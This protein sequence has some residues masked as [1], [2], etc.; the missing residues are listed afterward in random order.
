MK[1]IFIAMHYLEIG[2]AE[3][4]L[5]GL[6]HALDYSEVSVDLFLYARRGELL[7]EVPPQVNI[8]PEIPAYAHIES[9]LKDAFLHGHIRVGI[10]RLR[11]KALNRLRR[12]K[13]R[14][15][16]ESTAIFSYIGRC[17]TPALPQITDKVYDLAVS[18]LTPHDI[19]LRKVRARKKFCWIHTDYSHI[20]LDPDFELPV[21]QAYDRIISISPDVS[22]AFGSV[23]PSLTDRLTVISNILPENMIRCRASEGSAPELKAGC[24]NLLSIGR[25]SAAKNFDN[26]PDIARRMRDRH[27]ISSFH[28]FIIGYGGDEDL[29]RRKIAEAGVGDCVTILGKRANPYPYIARCDLYVQPSRYEGRCVT[30]REAQ[31]LGKP[32]VIAAW[33]TAPSQVCD[34][35]DGFIFP[36]SNDAFA[37]GLARLIASPDRI[38]GVARNL[39]ATDFSDRAEARKLVSLI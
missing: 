14:G 13:L 20:A 9:P 33:P 35:T 3:N 30:V 17:V 18:F 29:I 27:S 39:S 36:Q 2:G 37:A 21:W 38:A 24:F 4:A 28:W 26:I 12:R 8:L 25:F 10:G 7:S 15:T 1:Q 34:G 22:R 5:I 11:A 23:F 19:V 6:L 31:L 32:P 16:G